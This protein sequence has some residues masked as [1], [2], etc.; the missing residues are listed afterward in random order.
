MGEAVICRIAKKADA[1]TL[2]GFNVALAAETEDKKLDAAILS[3]GVER[4]FNLPQYGF[5]IVAE[6]D[7]SIAGS[8]LITYEWSDWRNGLFW[9]IQSVYVA[10]EFRRRGVYRALHSF[11]RE[12]ASRDDDVRGLRLYVESENTGAHRAY[13]QLGMEETSYKF[14]EEVFARQ[15]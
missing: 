13:E 3:P 2:I 7:G 14:F 5:Y 8:L 6:C 10:P 11:A 1:P 12:L 15:M 4:L 9:W